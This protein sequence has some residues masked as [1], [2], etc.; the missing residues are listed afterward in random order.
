MCREQNDY[1]LTRDHFHIKF[2]LQGQKNIFSNFCEK[3]W[4]AFSIL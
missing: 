1:V 3:C 2:K 4:L